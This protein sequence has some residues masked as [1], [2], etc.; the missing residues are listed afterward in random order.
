M[1]KSN[2]LKFLVHSPTGDQEKLAS[3]FEIFMNDSEKRKTFLLKGYAGTG[4]TTFINALAKALPALNYNVVL[5]A[6]TGRAAKVITSYSGR[7]AVTIHKK[8]YAL[9]SGKDGSLHISLHDWNKKPD[10]VYIVD[11]ASMISSRSDGGTVFGDR[12]LLQDLFD[13]VYERPNCFLV[14]SGDTAQLPPVNET[15]SRSLDAKFMSSMFHTKIY[16]FELREVVRQARE[17]G[18]LMN[19]T[20]LRILAGRM[21]KFPVLK[22]DGFK[23]VESINGNEAGELIQDKFGNRFNDEVLVV[24]RSNRQANRY[25]QHIRTAVLGQEDEISSSDSLMV[26]KNNYYWMPEK[27]GSGFIANGDIIRIKRILKREEKY[28]FRF[29][30]VIITLVDYPGHDELEAR[31]LLDTIS[32]E[33]PALTPAESKKLF[34]S[35]ASDYSTGKGGKI[36]YKKLYQ[37]PYLNALQV[38]FSYAVTCHK[39]QGGQWN[40]VFVD[41]GYM[42]DEMYNPEY[43]RWLYTAVTRA[44]KK[45]YLVNLS[46]TFFKKDKE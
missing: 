28:G 3:L 42:T 21:E 44:R 38:K 7:E 2:L 14:F 36:N 10:T 13:Y 40:E 8:I 43:L 9:E 32:S 16:Q 4:K 22:T 27:S 46:E 45:L 35:I 31:I 25:N 5:L 23:D 1:F 11:E 39:A 30:D 33:S 12:N 26:V 24:C 34:N 15:E 29:A 37:D 19:A 41:P 18:I 17:S 20:S 6:P